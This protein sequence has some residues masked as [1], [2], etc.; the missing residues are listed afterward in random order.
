MNAVQFVEA[1]CSNLLPDGACL[2]AM[3]MPDLSIP[4]CRSRPRCLVM[5]GTRCVHFEEC[6]VHMADNASDHRRALDLQEAVADYRKRT[7]QGPITAR[8]CPEC[9]GAVQKNKRM[10][11]ACAQKHRKTS[12]RTAQARRRRS[13]DVGSAEDQKNAPESL[14]NTQDIR[15]VFGIPGEDSGHPKTSKLLLTAGHYVS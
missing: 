11:P 13:R 8:A 6:A 1:E 15:P 3:I 10:C 7:N 5:D 9:G 14:R 2:G 4:F 12:N